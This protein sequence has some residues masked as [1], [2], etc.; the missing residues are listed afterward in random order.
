MFDRKEGVYVYGLY[1]EGAGWDKRNSYIIESVH[2]VLFVQMPIIHIFAV[3]E[4]PKLTDEIYACPLYKKPSR[5]DS[6]YVT[7]LYLPCKKLSSYWILAG[8]SLLCDNK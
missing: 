4:A 7:S 2:R 5:T 8:V 6:Q 3:N 1:L